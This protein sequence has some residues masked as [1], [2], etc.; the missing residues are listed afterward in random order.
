MND[1]RC[2]QKLMTGRHTD[3]RYSKWAASPWRVSALGKASMTS[4]ARSFTPASL[5]AALV[6]PSK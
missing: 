4:K 1:K 5:R 3:S 2:A 6:S